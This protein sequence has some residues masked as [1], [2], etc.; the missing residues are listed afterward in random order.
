MNPP[1]PCT[2]SRILPTESGTRNINHSDPHQSPL[3]SLPPSPSPSPSGLEQPQKQCA[4]L[5]DHVCA[6]V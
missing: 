3:P 4:N 5:F 2:P 1:P 6:G